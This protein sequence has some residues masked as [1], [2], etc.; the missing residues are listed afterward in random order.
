MQPEFGTIQFA[1]K[2]LETICYKVT[3]LQRLALVN[4]GGEADM[5]FE[6]PL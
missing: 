3:L 4:R 2:R 1:A 6:Y 5:A